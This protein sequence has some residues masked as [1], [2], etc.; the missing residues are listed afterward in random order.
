MTTEVSPNDRWKT[1]HDRAVRLGWFKKGEVWPWSTTSNFLMFQHHVVKYYFSTFGCIWV[2]PK[3][4][5]KPPK[6]SSLIGFSIINHPFWGTPMF[7]NTHVVKC[8]FNF[9]AH[10][11]YFFGGCE[12]TNSF[13]KVFISP[14]SKLQLGWGMLEDSGCPHKG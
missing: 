7:G 9:W 4:G 14:L 12:M 5:G 1:M 13:C 2:F 10:F 11:W 3:I 8:F 6:S